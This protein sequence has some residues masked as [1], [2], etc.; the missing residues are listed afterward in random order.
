MHEKTYQNKHD[1]Q[2][3]LLKYARLSLVFHMG[4][5]GAHYS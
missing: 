3:L 1:K 4:K 5:Y 2:L